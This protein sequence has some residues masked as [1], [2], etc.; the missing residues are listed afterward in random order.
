MIDNERWFMFLYVF[1]ELYFNIYVSRILDSVLHLTFYFALQRNKWS[2]IGVE[3]CGVIENIDN[4]H[5][6]SSIQNILEISKLNLFPHI[7]IG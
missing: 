1:T 2:R 3:M 5:G 4:W 7:L 6:L